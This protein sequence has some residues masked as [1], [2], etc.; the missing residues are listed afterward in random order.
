MYFIFQKRAQISNLF[1]ILSNVIH[2]RVRRILKLSLPHK[3]MWHFGVLLGKLNLMK[4]NLF[5]AR[6]LYEFQLLPLQLLPLGSR[7]KF[8]TNTTAVNY[9][10]ELK[11][12]A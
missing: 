1:A 7:I 3:I 11:I 10:F 4:N 6:L 5:I 8:R 2:Q 12:C 9:G